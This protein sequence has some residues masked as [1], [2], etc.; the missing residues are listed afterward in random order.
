MGR[1]S[2]LFGILNVRA[3]AVLVVFMT[4]MVFLVSTACTTHKVIKS[5][6]L[7]KTG[8]VTRTGNGPV[9]DGNEPPRNPYLADSYWPMT[10]KNSYCQASSPFPGPLGLEDARFDF[11]R[12]Y[13]AI[14][15]LITIAFSHPYA[16]GRVVIWG[17][18]VNCI[19]KAYPAR[20][21]IRIID[22]VKKKHSHR[23]SIKEGISGAYTIVD[24]DNTFFVPRLKKIY[25]YADS[26]EGDPDSRIVQKGI[27][28]IPEGY[29]RGKDDYVVGL[30]M[31]YDGMLAFAT[32]HG[33][34]GVVSRS[35]DRAYYYHCPAGEEISN[36]IACDED[37]GIYVVTSKHMYRVQWTG[38]RLSTD[39]KDKGWVANYDTG[40]NIEGIR[41]GQ[42]SGSTP[43]LMGAGRQDRFVVITDGQRLMNIVL[44]WRDRIP[45]D[46]VQIPGTKDR[47]IAAQVPVTFGNPDAIQSSSE[48]SVCV[49]GY[50]ALV[51]NNQ[52]KTKTRNRI[53]NILRSGNPGIAPYGAEKF[54]W[55]PK[56]RELKPVWANIKVSLPNGIPCMSAATN[57]VYDVG[58]RDGVWTWEAIDWNTGK[59]VFYYK[60][61]G[62]FWYNSGWAGTEIGPGRSLFSGT[63]LGMMRLEPIH[64]Q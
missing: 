17:S 20:D 11:R 64:E 47:R 62:H 59:S 42:G 27:F 56:A 25:A 18:A 28:T 32:S 45:D 52:L 53:I 57:L 39:G 49:R 33:T 58:Q 5:K 50:G 36:S 60:L 37:G 9:D 1:R 21:G 51:V 35:F 48:Q 38:N 30:N 24:K 7:A 6:L 61:G 23:F 46:W 40:S 41:L 29:L 44:F 55:D 63:V 31:T 22:L 34:V 19:F 15:G 10:H 12:G 13:R 26:V 2:R 4:S 8:I 54:E 16:D 43:T 3:P 14:G